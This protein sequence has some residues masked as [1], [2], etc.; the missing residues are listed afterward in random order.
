MPRTLSPRQQ[1]QARHRRVRKRVIGSAERPRLT[2]FRSLRQI[3][4]QVVNDD[5][6]HTLVAASSLH[7]ASAGKLAGMSKKEIAG[8]IGTEI[9]ERS[10]VI[11]ISQV[12]FD[13]GGYKFH[14]R[15][16]ALAEAAREGGLKF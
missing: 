7:P 10:K 1:R 15:I 16:K 4:A 14:G 8:V 3:Y 6:G 9:A 2:V 11:G 5:T 12:V 13:R